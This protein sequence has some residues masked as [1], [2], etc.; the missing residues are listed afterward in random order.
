MAKGDGR[1]RWGVYSMCHRKQLEYLG[2]WKTIQ[3]AVRRY[4]SG[5]QESAIPGWPL[6][7]PTL[8]MMVWA[9]VWQ[10]LDRET[11]ADWEDILKANPSGCSDGLDIRNRKRKEWSL[12]GSWLDP[13][14]RWLWWFL[15]DFLSSA[16][17]FPFSTLLCDAGAGTVQITFL[18]CHLALGW[19]LAIAGA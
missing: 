3:I 1:P 17:D 18:L 7:S 15:G 19:A 14:G 8:D 4:I 11:W 13:A 16:P 6:H 10:C 5:S 12:A 2:F 9:K